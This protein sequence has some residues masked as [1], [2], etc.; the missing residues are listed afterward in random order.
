MDEDAELEGILSKS[1]DSA[2]NSSPQISEAQS[3]RIKRAKTK[4]RDSKIN[5]DKVGKLDQIR[6]GYRNK[7]MKVLTEQSSE[8]SDDGESKDTE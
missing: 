1:K 5:T 8:S 4:K 7:A 3:P 2:E 6:A